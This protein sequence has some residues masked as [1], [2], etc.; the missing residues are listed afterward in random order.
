VREVLE[1]FRAQSAENAASV[2]MVEPGD[3][4]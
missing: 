4:A 3:A 2:V 1:R